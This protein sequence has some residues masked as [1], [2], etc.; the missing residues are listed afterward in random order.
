MPDP[1][2]NSDLHGSAPDN[3]PVALLLLEVINDFDY[4]DGE[5]LFECA[6]PTVPRLRQL[7][8]AAKA[9]AVPV[10]YV[11]DN[12]G[13]WQ[14]DFK[15]L[16]EHC[17]ET[18]RGR[19]FAAQLTPDDDDYFVLKPKHS[20]F[21]G[22]T[23]ELLLRYLQART[24][25]LAGLTGDMCVLFTAMDA[26]LRDFHLVIPADCV[27]SCVVEHNDHALAHMQRVLK[28]DIVTSETLEF[29]A[30]KRRHD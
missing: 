13:R 10:L 29:H 23:L 26:Y 21:Y 15:K 7:K 17:L 12:F 4:P 2:K 22:T 9:A 18:E 14:S 19:A 24:V 6:R 27:A 20:G 16:I 11:N 5:K 25:V 28:A 8:R 30:L 3:S 1:P